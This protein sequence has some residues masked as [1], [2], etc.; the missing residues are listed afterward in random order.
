MG[1]QDESQGAFNKHIKPKQAVKC[2]GR[3]AATSRDK[4][5]RRGDF[6][7]CLVK[8]LIHVFRRRR[9]DATGEARRRGWGLR[10]SFL[11]S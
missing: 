2:R 6:F 8:R 4:G 5:V 3:N 9:G 1:S 7:L 11:V 10:G